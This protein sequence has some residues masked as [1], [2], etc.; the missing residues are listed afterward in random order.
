MKGKERRKE[1]ENKE[2]W[3]M[4]VE[5]GREK[6]RRKDEKTEIKSRKGLES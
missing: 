5:C 6:L 4:N 1:N 3:K 2:K